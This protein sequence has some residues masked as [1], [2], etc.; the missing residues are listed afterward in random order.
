MEHTQLDAWKEAIELTID[1]YALTKVFP[2]EELFGITSQLRRAVVSIPSNIAEGCARKSSAETIHFLYIAIGSIAE[3]ETQLI[4]SKKLGYCSD[5]DE[6]FKR[7]LLVKQ[8]TLG[9][10]KYLKKTLAP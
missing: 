2:K 3:V 6:L 1:V 5:I 4:I 7:L 8:L 9:L 10:V